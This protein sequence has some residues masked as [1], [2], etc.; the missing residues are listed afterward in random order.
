MNRLSIVFISNLKLRVLPRL[1]ELHYNRIPLY[2][3]KKKSKSSYFEKGFNYKFKDS[4]EFDTQSFKFRKLTELL[5]L[6]IQ[7][8]CRL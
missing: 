6:Q 1:L 5:Q 3:G 7:R 4:V 8:F 2:I